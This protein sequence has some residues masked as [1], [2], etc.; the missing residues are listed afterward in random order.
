M[1]KDIPWDPTWTIFL[2]RDGVINKKLASYVTR[3]SEFEFLPGALDAVKYLSENFIR[4]VVVT[5]QQGIGKKLM[6]HDDLHSVHAHMLR[7]IEL[8]GG[9][10]DNVYYC[11]YLATEDPLCRKPNPGMALQAKDDFPDILFEESIM[12]GDSPSDIGFGN[13]LGMK[14]IRLSHIPDPSAYETFP[15]L[16]SFVRYCKELL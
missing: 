1:Y 2:D 10:I 16:I 14:T 15:S 13:Q 8:Y 7:N 3:P 11:P 6:S 12:I 9:R 4:I 5:N